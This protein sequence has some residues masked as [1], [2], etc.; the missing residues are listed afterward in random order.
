MTKEMLIVTIKDNKYAIDISIVKEIIQ[1]KDLREIPNTSS[2]IDGVMEYKGKALSICSA[3]KLL[4][5]DGFYEEQEKVLQT[6]EKMH[7][8]W[9]EALKDSIENDAPFEKTFDPHACYLGKWIDKMLSCSKCNNKGF[10]NLIHQHVIPHHNELHR[11][12]KEIYELSK[13]DKEKA[14]QR[15]QEET[16]KDY[17][18][19]LGGL[20]SLEDKLD[21]LVKSFERV[22]VCSIEDHTFGLCVDEI[23]KIHEID[24]KIFQPI[25]NNDSDKYLITNKSFFFNGEVVLVLEFKENFLHEITV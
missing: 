14:K 20:T 18:N 10:V 13:K 23:D 11:E 16:L 12:G 17:K 2:V 9:V 6:V 15:F 22:L 21:L 1:K 8:A 25:T 7:I 4:N 3:R 5:H 19:T 24:T